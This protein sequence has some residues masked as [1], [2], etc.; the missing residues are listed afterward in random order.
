MAQFQ[1]EHEGSNGWAIYPSKDI[2][3]DN[4]QNI[5]VAECE[6]KTVNGERTFTLHKSQETICGEKLISLQKGRRDILVSA[7]ASKIR[8][9][10]ANLQNGGNEVCGV[11]VSH[12]YA[13]SEQ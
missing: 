1:F 4:A 9:L 7:D 10:L 8:S 13:D 5:H 6:I 11:C 3:A 2:D 12:F